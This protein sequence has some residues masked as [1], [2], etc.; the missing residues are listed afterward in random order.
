[1][2]ESPDTVFAFVDIADPLIAWLAYRGEMVSSHDVHSRALSVWHARRLERIDVS[3]ERLERY[4][5]E[6]ALEAIRST[7]FAQSVSRLRGFYVFPDEETALRASAAWGGSFKAESL[8]EIG[9]LPDAEFSRYDSEWITNSAKI[10]PAR[11]ADSYFSGAAQGKLPLWELVVRGRGVIFGTEL[12]EAAYRR[13]EEE[14]PASLALLE[15]ARVA[16]ELQSDLGVCTAMIF[17]D[18]KKLLVDYVINFEDA[19]NPDF[20]KRFGAYDGPKNVKDLNPS[21]DLVVPDLRSR[22]FRIA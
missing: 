16:V 17:G 2:S 8:V 5:R 15:L 20:L 13:V 4:A 19:T 6:V 14:W 9:L 11:W 12:R 18:G 22:R 1:M 7:S 3:K 21:S 10:D